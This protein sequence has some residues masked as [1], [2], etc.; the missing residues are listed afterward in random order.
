MTKYL[1]LIFHLFDWKGIRNLDFIRT[2]S[3]FENKN[4]GEYMTFDLLSTVEY[5]G[6]SAKISADALAEALKDLP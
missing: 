6:C 4:P 5:G 3:L 2:H 1:Y